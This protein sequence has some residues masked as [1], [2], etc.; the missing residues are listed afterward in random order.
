MDG[1][2][3]GDF[4]RSA[5]CKFLDLPARSTW[6]SAPFSLKTLHWSVFRALEPSKPSKSAIASVEKFTRQLTALECV[7]KMPEAQLAGNSVV[8]TA[9]LTAFLR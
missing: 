5:A 7:S 1:S 9:S 3:A 6:G 8:F 4:Q 2:L